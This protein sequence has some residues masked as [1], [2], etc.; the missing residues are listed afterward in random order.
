[1]S[2]DWPIEWVG[3]GGTELKFILLHPHLAAVAFLALC[4]L[5]CA[6]LAF[7]A[8]VSLLAASF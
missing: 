6:E 1:L 4:K 2:I 5:M 7:W 8:M 3:G